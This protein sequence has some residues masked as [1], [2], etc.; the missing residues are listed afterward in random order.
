MIKDRRVRQNSNLA[1]SETLHLRKT[2]SCMGERVG[3][4]ERMPDSERE[5]RES[6]GKITH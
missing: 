4:L 3:E 5:R 2:N 6:R 1:E